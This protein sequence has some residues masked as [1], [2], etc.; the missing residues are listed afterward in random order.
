MYAELMGV[1]VILAAPWI[2]NE[3]ETTPDGKHRFTIADAYGEAGLLVTYASTYEGFGNAFLEAVYYRKPIMCNRYSIYRTDI[4]PCGFDSIVM[5]GF[6]TNKVVDQVRLVLRDEDR[7]QRM[8]EH[9]YDVA[10]RFFSY[11]RAENGA[12]R[13]SPQLCLIL[14]QK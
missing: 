5:D 1:E 9:N 10:K 8:V 2:A 12:A 4:E 11:H 14:Q 7:R 3:R 13:S 6:L